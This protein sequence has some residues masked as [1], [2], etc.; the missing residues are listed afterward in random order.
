MFQLEDELR[1]CMTGLYMMNK[2]LFFLTE[3]SKTTLVESQ[4]KIQVQG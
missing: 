3:S 4:K 2:D 1:G